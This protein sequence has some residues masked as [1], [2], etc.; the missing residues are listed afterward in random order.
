VGSDARADR[1]VPR[2]SGSSIPG[3]ERERGRSLAG[4]AHRS[5]TQT[6]GRGKRRGPDRRGHREVGP[7]S[8]RWRARASATSQPRADGRGP[9]GGDTEQ[10][11][12]GRRCA[13]V[14]DLGSTGQRPR[15]GDEEAERGETDGRVLLVRTAIF[16]GHAHGTSAMAKV[17][18]STRAKKA[19]AVVVGRG[20]LGSTARNRHRRSPATNQRDRENRGERKGGPAG[21]FT[22][23]GAGTMARMWLTVAEHGRGR[24][25]SSTGGGFGHRRPGGGEAPATLKNGCAQ[26]G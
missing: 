13:D 8:Q 24:W 23:G 19:R 22:L 5:A 18:D 16:L 12:R 7:A 17:G 9:P 25:L 10:G 4:G 14:W 21:K 6:I 2:V 3:A 1:R 26:L 20:V 15:E 11:G